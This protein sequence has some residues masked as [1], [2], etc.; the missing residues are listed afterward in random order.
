MLSP[1]VRTPSAFV[2]LT[3][4]PS[5]A[6]RQFRTRTDKV[7]SRPLRSLRCNSADFSMICVCFHQSLR[8]MVAHAATGTQR[9]QSVFPG[10]RDT[11]PT[12]LSR[13][14][15]VDSETPCRRAAKRVRTVRQLYRCG[16]LL[17]DFVHG[18]SM[19][20]CDL[21]ATPFCRAPLGIS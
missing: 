10:L 6:T 13:L 3:T 14:L 16:D 21:Y 11:L 18:F 8:A 9:L 19:N 17:D 2:I 5:E 7:F 4:G 12:V 1:L 20:R 15:T